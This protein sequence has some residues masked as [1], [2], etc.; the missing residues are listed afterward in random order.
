MSRTR[1]AVPPILVSEKCPFDYLN[2]TQHTSVTI[3][4]TSSRNFI[5]MCIR[6]IRYAGTV[7][8]TFHF[9][10]QSYDP[11]IVLGLGFFCLFCVIFILVLPITQ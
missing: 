2:R 1:M 4:Y 6:L 8:V 11:F 3:K 9:S 5:A 7:M 10:F